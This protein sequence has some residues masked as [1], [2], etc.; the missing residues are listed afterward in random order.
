MSK[1]KKKPAKKVAKKAPRKTRRDVAEIAREN[2]EQIIGEKL[3]GEPLDT[4]EE[5]PDTRNQAAV[6]L[7]KLGASKGGKA[8]AKKLSAKKR[9]EIAK[10]AAKAR[11]GRSRK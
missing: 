2:L 11:W 7:S 10:R 1:H 6:E 9:S 5:M 3:N 8:R 4:P